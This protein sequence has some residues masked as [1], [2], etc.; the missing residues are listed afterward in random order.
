MHKS[1]KALPGLS[2]SLKRKDYIGNKNY[3]EV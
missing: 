3:L 2:K 1:G